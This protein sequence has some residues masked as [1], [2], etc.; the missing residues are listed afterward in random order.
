LVEYQSIEDFGF[1]Q[2]GCLASASRRRAKINC[3]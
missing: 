2:K 3:D 1:S